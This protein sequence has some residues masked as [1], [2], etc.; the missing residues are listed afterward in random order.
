M[1]EKTPE[2]QLPPITILPNGAN[3]A[4]REASLNAVLSS[5]GYPELLFML[6]EVFERRV[7]KV[8]LDYRRENVAVRFNIDG[9]WHEFPERDRVSG[10]CLLAVLKR[11]AD[12]DYTERRAKQ[13]AEFGAKYRAKTIR[14]KFTSQGVRT[15]ER[16]LVEV[17][18][19]GTA[20]DKFEQTSIRKSMLDQWIELLKKPSGMLLTSA[21]PGDGKT[22]IWRCTM[23]AADRFIRDFFSFE[24]KGAKEPDIINIE[25]QLY[26]AAAGETP[27]KLLPQ[28]M[29]RQPDVL[30]LPDLVDG[31]VV[32]EFCEQAIDHEKFVIGHVPAR[33]ATEALVRVLALGANPEFFAKT[34]QGVLYQRVIRKLCDNCRQPYDPHPELLKKL[35]IRPGRVQALYAQWQPPPPE[36]LVDEKGNPIEVPV[37]P[38]C[39]GVGYLGRAAIYELIVINDEIREALKTK[40]TVAQL[41]AITAKHHVELRDEGVVLVAKGA[42]SVEEL[43][44]VL[45]R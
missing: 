40:P 27:L 38:R 45:Q 4:A 9:V 18:Y 30:C 41:A 24:N 34:I 14:L 11:I 5:P 7:E 20:I 8:L 28:A 16:V 23:H 36:E 42:T 29:L 26:D 21:M 19:P 17:L 6:V 12:L 31:E 13:Q 10:D 44:R 22:T 33:N 25:A 37:C 1:A 2:I 39:Y 43:Q 32:D 35:G 15:G 3:D